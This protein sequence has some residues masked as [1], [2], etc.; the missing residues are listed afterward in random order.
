MAFLTM[1][2]QPSGGECQRRARSGLTPSVAGYQDPG[3]AHS[4]VRTFR[5]FGHGL[6][7]WAPAAR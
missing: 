6:G 7:T 2:V 5:T 3:T 1:E 4:S